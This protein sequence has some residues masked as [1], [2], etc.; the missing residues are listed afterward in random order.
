M[1][2]EV[3]AN[4]RVVAVFYGHPGVFVHPSHKSIAEA[5]YHGYEAEMLPAVSTKKL[6]HHIFTKNVRHNTFHQEHAPPH[7]YHS[8]SSIHLIK[9]QETAST[10][11]YP[12]DI[13]YISAE[14]CLFADVGVDPALP[15]YQTF[16]ATDLLLN[17]R[18]I[19]TDLHVVIWQVCV[20]VAVLFSVSITIN[21]RTTRTANLTLYNRLDVWVCLGSTSRLSITSTSSSWWT[22]F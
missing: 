11:C 12:P 4:K 21:N 5:R 1:I 16:E 7:L 8:H 13:L 17:A 2:A 14:D 15:G 20:W 22:T 10:L 6:C 18:E 9:S 3:R 19:C